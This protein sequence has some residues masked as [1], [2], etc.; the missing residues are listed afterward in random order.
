M[1]NGMSSCIFNYKISYNSSYRTLCAQLNNKKRIICVSIE[2][3]FNRPRK[4]TT[5]PKS[6]QA[7]SFKY[8]H[9]DIVK[10]WNMNPCI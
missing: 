7:N 2:K 5:T 1:R 8:V 9:V 3:L 6:L 10:A 4:I